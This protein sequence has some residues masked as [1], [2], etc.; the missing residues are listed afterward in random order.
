VLQKD[1]K[2]YQF[3]LFGHSSGKSLSGSLYFGISSKA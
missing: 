3:M 1:R 2:N